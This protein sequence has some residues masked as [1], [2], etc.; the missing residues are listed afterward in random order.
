MAGTC[1]W[2]GGRPRP[3][4][5]HRLGQNSIL[6]PQQ[7][8]NNFNFSSVPREQ[9]ATR[10]GQRGSLYLSVSFEE[11]T[12]RHPSSGGGHQREGAGGVRCVS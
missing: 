5:G 8:Q 7:R 12:R 3:A 11:S 9:A 4:A 10:G 6:R 1:A 2:R